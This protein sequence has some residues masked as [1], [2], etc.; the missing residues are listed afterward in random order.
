M[1]S[2][3]GLT[4]TVEPWNLFIQD[5]YS[6]QLGT[7]CSVLIR[8][9]SLS[10]TS[11]FR[12]DCSV[13]IRGVAGINHYSGT[14]E[15]LYSGQTRVLIRGVRGLISGVNYSGTREPIQDSLR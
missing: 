15:P 12:T 8:G 3:Q 7:D 9:D 14:L 10:G 11:L 6:G 4:I 13:L 2:F 5:S 1:A